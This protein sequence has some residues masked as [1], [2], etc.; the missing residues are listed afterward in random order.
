[1]NIRKRIATE[2]HTQARRNFPRRAVTVKGLN[3]LYQADLVEMIPYARLNKGFKYIM[4]IIDC[5]SKYA[6]GIP[7]KNKSGYHVAKALDTV[8]RKVS[9]RHLQTDKGKEYYNSAVRA[10][11]NKHG[12]N[13]YSTFSEKKASI[14]ERLNRTLKSMMYRV[15]TEQGSY[16]WYPS[17]L[18]DIVKKY[19]DTPHRTI[20][21]KPR[22]V[23]LSNENIVLRNINTTTARNAKLMK[24]TKFNVEDKVRISK[25]KRTFAKGY[26]PNWTNE[27]FTI[28]E[29]RPTIPVTYYLRDYEGKPISGSF[30]EHELLKSTV[31]DVYLIEKIVQRKGDRVKVRWL[32]FD[33]THD[34]WINKKDLV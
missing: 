15:F 13:H 11:L 21:M 20:G 26:Q 30:Y 4:T 5:F 7:V 19:N 16:K 22:E 17:L 23:N 28:D 32:G 3:D 25:F 18:S 33:G 34:T 24:R 6:Y 1:M 12:V 10:I 2:L 31:G 8:L 14:V 27:V 29:V 9:M